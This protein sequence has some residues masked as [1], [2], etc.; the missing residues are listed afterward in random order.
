MQ[1][2]CSLRSCAVYRVYRPIRSYIIGI[3]TSNRGR[4]GPCAAAADLF[5]AILRRRGRKFTQH[6]H[7]SSNII[8]ISDDVTPYQLH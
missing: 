6:I 8:L 1:Q 7:C 3:G 4:V 2:R 5:S